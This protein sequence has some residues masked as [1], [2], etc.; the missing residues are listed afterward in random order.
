MISSMWNG[1]RLGVLH[2]PPLQA[3]GGSLFTTATQKYVSKHAYHLFTYLAL[4]LSSWW[5]FKFSE[6]NPT[7][8]T[9]L[10]VSTVGP[11]QL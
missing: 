8:L 10:L 5:F 11:F 7:I 2:R 6:P 4:S 9:I 1:R 3:S